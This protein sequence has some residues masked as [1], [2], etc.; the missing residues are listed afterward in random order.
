M[1]NSIDN[2]YMQRCI[3]IA[4][5]GK[6]NVAPNPLVGCVIVHDGTIIGE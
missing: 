4:K 3:D 5:H 6:G 2:K 1:L